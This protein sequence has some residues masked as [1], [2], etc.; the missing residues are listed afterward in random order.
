MG[1]PD[2]PLVPMAAV[3]A[4]ASQMASR[5]LS[6]L[7]LTSMACTVLGRRLPLWLRRLMLVVNI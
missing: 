2:N 7:N 1:T 6:H 4:Q 5:Q 3:H